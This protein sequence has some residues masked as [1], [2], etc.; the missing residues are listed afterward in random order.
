LRFNRPGARPAAIESQSRSL[1]LRRRNAA[2]AVPARW[3]STHRPPRAAP[4]DRF[5]TRSLSSRP[6]P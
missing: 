2:S 1:N 6:V 3:C 5:A 4:C